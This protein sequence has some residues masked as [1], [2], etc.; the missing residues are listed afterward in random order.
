MLILQKSTCA[1]GWLLGQFLSN[2]FNH[3][4]DAFGGHL[5]NRMK[6]PLEIIKAIRDIAKDQLLSVCV[7]CS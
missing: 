4:N 5:Q 3:R 6:L 7:K 1:H 2:Y